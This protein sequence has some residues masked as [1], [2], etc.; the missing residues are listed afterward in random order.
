MEGAFDQALEPGMTPCV[1][2]LVG[3]NGNY[4]IELEK[5]VLV[6]QDGAD[7]LSSYPFDAALM[8]G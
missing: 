8:G 5:Q 7:R 1:E 2:A 3:A 4:S 6:T